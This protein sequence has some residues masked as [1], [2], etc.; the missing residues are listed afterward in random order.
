MPNLLL[1]GLRR[2]LR[3]RYVLAFCC[4]LLSQQ[5]WPQDSVQEELNLGTGTSVTIQKYKVD[6]KPL[7]LWLPMEL[8]FRP[9]EERIARDL[10]NSGIEVWRADLAEAN[11][12]PPLASSIDQVPEQDLIALIEH[13]R[14]QRQPLVIMSAARGAVLA[15]RAVRAWQLAHPGQA[16]VSA[17]ILLHPNLYAPPR[18][19][20]EEAEY[21]PVVHVNNLPIFVLQ[22]E[23]S[24]WSWR[25]PGLVK[26][27][28]ANGAPVY[29]Q[30]LPGIRDRFYFRPDATELETASA[31]KL[32]VHIHRAF[33]LLSTHKPPSRAFA[34]SEKSGP[35][36]DRSIVK[37]GL[38]PYGGSP[39]PPPLKLPALAGDSTDIKD[40]R[41][42]VVLVNFWAT[43]CPP[44][45][46]EMPSMERL[47]NKLRDKPFTILAVNLAEA[48]NTIRQFLQQ[49]VQVS[50]P[51][52]LDQ[53]QHATRAWRVFAYPT[54]Y[55]VDRRG[56]IRYG[57]FGAMAWDDAEVLN[58]IAKLLGEK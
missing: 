10:A 57:A 40:L 26:A 46:H 51:I 34:G 23:Q 56:N 39:H 29:S 27:L 36:Q 44:C 22:P 28:E 35:A 3:R 33:K 25:L 31:A 42:Q 41:G 30:Y 50:F 32:N 38:L 18:A 45:V 6:G 49:K 53:Q 43:W 17:I 5:G 9:G 1:Y 58:V 55:L 24:P 13:V 48:E 47:K 16:G 54:T 21:L 20:G 14:R 37:K 15:M 4:C 11:F 19:P 7:L 2:E 12:L 52:L 8:G